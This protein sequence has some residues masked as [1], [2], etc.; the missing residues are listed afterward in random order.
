MIITNCPR[1]GSMNATTTCANCG[2]SQ[3]TTSTVSTRITGEIELKVSGKA[4]LDDYKR[5]LLENRNL[6]ERVAELEED[7][8]SLRDSNLWLKQNYEDLERDYGVMHEKMCARIDKL[9]GAI[10][11]LEDQQREA[12]NILIDKNLH[13]DSLYEEGYKLQQRIAELERDFDMLFRSSANK[14][15][16]KNTQTLTLPPEVQE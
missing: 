6:K 12:K 10:E 16:R 1:C 15:P 2:W 9:E 7:K 8:R 13:I 11:I 14:Q 3:F 4:L 5:L